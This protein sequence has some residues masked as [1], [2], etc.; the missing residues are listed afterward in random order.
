MS[1]PTDLKYTKDH[2][3]IR[4]DGGTGTVGITDFAQQQLGD[5]VYVELPEV[6][7]QLTAG[8]VF[9]TIESVKAVSELYAPVS[10]EVLEI[11]TGLKDHPDNVNS[12]P[13]E[14]W[15]VKVK[16]ANAGDAADL[17]DA[18]AYEALLAK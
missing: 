16:L 14:S 5:V 9:G 12:K 1:Y 6:G 3:W 17:L 15:M 13:H 2:E 4:L 7:T 11:N 8:K 18:T 10:G